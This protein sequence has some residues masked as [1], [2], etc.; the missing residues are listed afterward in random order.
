MSMSKYAS[1]DDYDNAQAQRDLK[2]HK[3][4]RFAMWKWC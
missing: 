4:A 2:P 1:R 3:A